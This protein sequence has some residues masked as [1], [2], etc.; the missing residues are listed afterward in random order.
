MRLLTLL[1]LCLLAL[2]LAA[3]GGDDPGEG[4]PS[5]TAQS[6][7]AELGAVERR[8][9]QGSVGACEDV[10]N[11]SVPA[12][13]R[14]LDSLPGATDPQLRSAL[15]DSFATLRTLSEQECDTRRQEAEDRKKETETT[16]AVPTPTEP[17][18][19]PPTTETTPPPTTQT[20]PKPDEKD[21]DKDKDK[22]KGKGKDK[23]DDGGSG[24]SESGQAPGDQGEGTGGS[25][26]QTIVPGADG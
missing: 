16:P 3:C 1:S 10:L 23:G 25:E 19:P 9:D 8:L 2:A 7:L 14:R 20:T 5:S 12:I 6:L 13:Q 11:Q 26:P 24:G 21:K 15:D 22:D 4:V 17:I 18:P